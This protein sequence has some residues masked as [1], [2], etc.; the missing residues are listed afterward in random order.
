MEQCGGRVKTENREEGNVEKL[1][2]WWTIG[3]GGELL[4]DF[5]GSKTNQNTFLL[6]LCSNYEQIGA[7]RAAIGRGRNDRNTATDDA[8]ATRCSHV[9]AKT[10]RS[11][12]EKRL[13]S[14]GVTRT[15]SESSSYRVLTRPSRRGGVSVVQ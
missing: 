3:G 4:G 1:D 6:V 9:A 11:R 5:Y 13:F 15:E 8:T 14:R 10:C 2:S 12:S 7:T